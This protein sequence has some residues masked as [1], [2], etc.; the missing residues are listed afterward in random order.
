MEGEGEGR[1]RLTKCLTSWVQR[2]GR[3]LRGRRG[4]SRGNWRSLLDVFLDRCQRQLAMLKLR[5][6]Q[7]RKEQAQVQ[8]RGAQ[9]GRKSQKAKVGGVK[10]RDRSI[11]VVFEKLQ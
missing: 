11:S 4:E 3:L 8:I 1:L 7:F 10:C 6:V 2:T 5:H 9:K